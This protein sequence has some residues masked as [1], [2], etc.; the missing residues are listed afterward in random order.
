[1][2]TNKEMTLV[3]AIP[4]RFSTDGFLAFPRGL[5]EALRVAITA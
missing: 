2:R 3:T 1:M 4:I 5:D